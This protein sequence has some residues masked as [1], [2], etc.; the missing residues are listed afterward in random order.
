MKHFKKQTSFIILKNG[1]N[2]PAISKTTFHA[3]C[4]VIVLLHAM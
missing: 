3:F 1:K 2:F 4:Y